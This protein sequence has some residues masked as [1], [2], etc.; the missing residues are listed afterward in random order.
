MKQARVL[1]DAEF[2]RL[3]AVVAQTKHAGRNRLALM[4]SHLAGLRVGEI[5]ALT[6]RDVVDAEGRVREQLRL[7]AEI[8]KGGHARVVFLNEKLRR[9]I[10]RHQ[11]DWPDCRDA[12]AP[13]LLT[14]K[15]TAFSANTLCQ[16]MGQL[17]KSAG[18][19]GATSHSGRRWFI[20]RLAHSGVSPK[21]IMT[22][23]GHRN[24]TTTQRYIDV[25]DDMMKAAVD[26][27]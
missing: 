16:L 20:T 14:Q 26:L 1:T 6:V 13:F 25:R 11:S 24:L 9:E 15:R 22:L 21:V 2:K 4:L 3:L 10:A 27:L 5:A 12:D 7:R 23:A 17:Y 19:D 18:L 8:T